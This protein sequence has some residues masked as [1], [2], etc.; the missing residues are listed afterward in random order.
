MI[1]LINPHSQQ[2]RARCILRD[3]CWGGS[4]VGG[5]NR[6]APLQGH[7]RP[8]LQT[9][10]RVDQAL[11]RL[12][13]GSTVRPLLQTDDPKATLHTLLNQRRPLYGEADLTLVINEEPPKQSLTGSSRC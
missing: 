8:D 1:D 4:L 13:A 5:S 6:T 10:G 11:H 12:K 7:S 9:T 2:T 3:V